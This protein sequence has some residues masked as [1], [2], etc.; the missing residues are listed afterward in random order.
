M[1]KTVDNVNSNTYLGTVYWSYCC[2]HQRP[3]T[4]SYDQYACSKLSVLFMANEKTS[5][6]R[7][8][9]LTAESSKNTILQGYYATSTGKYLL[10]GRNGFIFIIKLDPKRG[11]NYDL[12]KRP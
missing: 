12:P 1:P 6:I 5:R 4:K 3:Y 2:L 10:K 9:A 7:H 8:E 11:R